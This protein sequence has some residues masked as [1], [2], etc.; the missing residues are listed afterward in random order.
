[1]A[2]ILNYG[3]LNLDY[4]YDVPHFVA[5]GETLSSTRLTL[6]CG[7]KGLNQSIALARAGAQVFH[8]GKIGKNGGM[9]KELLKK[10]GVETR[11][12]TQSQG[13][14]GHAV[15]QVSPDGQNCIL[16]YGGSNQEITREEI[17][18]CL[19]SFQSDD[20]LVLQ[21]EINDLPYLL[22]RAAEKGMRVA[23]NPSPITPQLL[24]TP[25]T[26][27]TLLALNEIE[28]EALSGRREPEE[29]AQTLLRKYP[30]CAILLTL[31]TKGAVYLDKYQMLSHGIYRTKAVD[32]TAA[33]DTFTGFFVACAAS[34][35]SP[36][37]A[38]E[39]ASKASSIAVSRMGAAPSIPTMDE[40]KR[41]KLI[42][43][44]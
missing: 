22:R 11:F 21:N 35:E 13:E 25:L 44:S 37:T 23:L 29:I 4:V 38:L 32:T 39:L 16:L 20:Y 7:G 9:L 27:V 34:G 24:E 26:G 19:D 28:G 36:Q 1:M 40:V 43:Q 10:E 15:I 17:D 6:N 12:I 18:D 30:E 42:L 33:G 3:S 8:A 14:N 5:A 41:A 31:G 2:R